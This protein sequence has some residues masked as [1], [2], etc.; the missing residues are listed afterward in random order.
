MPEGAAPRRG[1]PRMRLDDS[2]ASPIRFS[3]MAA[4]GEDVE[5]DFRTVGEILD[6]G[7]SALSKALSYL[8]DVGYV[9]TRKGVVAGRA[10]TWVRASRAGR[11][12]FA[13]HLAALRE[14]VELGGGTGL[15]P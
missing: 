5:L 7:D 3:A 9:E 10:R 6:V 11:E 8:H 4:L 15:S 1:H 2:F 13:A 12:A 14:I